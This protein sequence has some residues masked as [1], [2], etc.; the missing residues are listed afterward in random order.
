MSQRSTIPLPDLLAVCERLYARDG[1]V[2]WQDVGD[3]LGISRQAVQLRLKAAVAKGDLTPE[4][5]ERFQS[6]A[7]RRSAARERAR[8][9]RAAA[10]AQARLTISAQLLPENVQWLRSEA[11]LR[12]AT[13]ADI[14]NGLVTKARSAGEAVPPSA[15]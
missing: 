5:V 8:A 15:E 11:V 9:G 10:A 3:A 14:L 7:S 12:R 1:F 13:A 6:V 4:S 2:K